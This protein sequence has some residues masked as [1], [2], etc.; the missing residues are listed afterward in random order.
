MTTPA[1]EA[2]LAF[3]TNFEEYTRPFGVTLYNG[4]TLVGEITSAQLASGLSDA[5]GP[6]AE[7]VNISV[8]NGGTYT[9][10]VF[11]GND[12][13]LLFAISY[14]SAAEDL[15]TLTPLTDGVPLPALA[16]TLPGF[17][18]AVLGMFG[19]RRRA[20]RARCA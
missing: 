16:G 8:A 12:N 17:A 5:W 18:A 11:T 4:S 9:S 20:R 10:A 7:Y 1:P 6:D 14:G 15:T 2:Y 3:V 19:L 13:S